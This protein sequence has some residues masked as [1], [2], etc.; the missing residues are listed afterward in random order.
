MLSKR[1]RLFLLS[2]FLA[3]ILF[4]LALLNPP[5]VL[6]EPCTDWKLN[7]SA[8]GT[9]Y[10][11]ARYP[12][13]KFTFRMTDVRGGDLFTICS[14]HCGGPFTNSFI[15]YHQVLK[16]GENEREIK[17]KIDANDYGNHTLRIRNENIEPGQDVCRFKYSVKYV[18]KEAEYSNCAL[19]ISSEKDPENGKELTP[20]TI[21][22]L[23]GTQIPNE[24]NQ[25]YIIM[26]EGIT[27]VEKKKIT[28]RFDVNLS[29]KPLASFP[30]IS[31]DR[32]LE[33]SYTVS[34]YTF[35]TD[36]YGDA[37]GANNPVPTGCRDGFYISYEGG[38]V[39]PVGEEKIKELCANVEP[40]DSQKACRDCFDDDKTW[41]ALGCIPT[42]DLDDFVGWIL[43]RVVFIATGIAFILLVIGALQILT[44]AGDPEK[45]KAGSELLTSTIAGLLLI[46]LSLFLLKLIGV[47]ILHLPGF[48]K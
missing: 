7:N 21:I 42:D 39:E 43:G 22:Y 29:G 6:A 36:N 17:D 8:D 3:I 19:N 1:K 30:K 45:V 12:Q 23:E 11:N 24:D 40:K 5:K 48:N 26:V 38:G 46:I 16:E 14:D 20:N 27:T 4:F 47:D 32:Y 10:T 41:T 15:Q 25:G 2:P 31:L 33:G 37:Y 13:L 35:R 18:G 28:R 44:S 34:L 9:I